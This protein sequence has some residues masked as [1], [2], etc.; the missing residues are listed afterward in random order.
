MNFLIT[1][2]PLTKLPPLLTCIHPLL[3]PSLAP[4]SHTLSVPLLPPTWLHLVGQ[5]HPRGRPPELVLGGL[6][7]SRTRPGD[8][9][10]GPAEAE[11]VDP[12]RRPDED[13][14][15]P[16]GAGCGLEDAEVSRQ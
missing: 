11:E 7:R 15:L 16:R 4:P 10:A 5:A 13:H 6:R 14:Q 12:H 8:H 2:L 9:A 1:H 3:T